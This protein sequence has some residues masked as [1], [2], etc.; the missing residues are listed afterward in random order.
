[1][2]TASFSTRSSVQDFGGNRIDFRGGAV[3]SAH[4][5]TVQDKGAT[6]PVTRWDLE[7]CIS[8]VFNPGKEMIG[9]NRTPMNA[10]NTLAAI[11][12]DPALERRYFVRR[13]SHVS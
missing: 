11:E 4:R 13:R 5:F 2:R 10:P 8:G 7:A 3:G 9:R 12:N 1:M 6:L